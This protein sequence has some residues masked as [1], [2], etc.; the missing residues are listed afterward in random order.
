[1]KRFYSHKLK[2][3]V[4]MLRAGEYYVSST[5]EVLYT[6]LG[7]CM[8][9]CL[10]DPGLNIGGMNHFLLPG[11]VHPD[12][13]FTSEVGRYGMYAMEL[14]IGDLIKRGAR[15]EMLKAKVFGGGAVLKFRKGDGDV[16]GS[17]VRFATRFLQL[18]GIPTEVADVGG[19]QG[20]KILFF[21]D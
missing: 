21:S 15:R 12:E 2:K 9:V 16:T 20:R 13:I 7:S 1:M 14:L 4:I 11:M 18:E 3:H 19:R 17:N 6:L 8:A 10:Y 5:G